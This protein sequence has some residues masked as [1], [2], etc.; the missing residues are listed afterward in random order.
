MKCFLAASSAEG[1]ISHFPDCYDPDGGWSAY[2]IK[3]GPGTGKSSFMKRV[4]KT[5]SERAKPS[6]EVHCASDP[7]SLDGVIL[8][9]ERIAIMDGT[10]PHVVEPRFV[11]AVETLL[12]FGRFWDANAL[13]RGREEI[14][15]LTLRNKELHKKAGAHISSAGAALKE[16]LA[17][18]QADPRRAETLS[19]EL[20]EKHLPIEGKGGR[21][22][23]AF[24]GGVTPTGL[25]YITEGE[26]AEKSIILD[27]SLDFASEV[28]R[29]FKA[30]ALNR[31]FETV[32][33][34]N[35]ILPSRLTDGVFIPALSLY[36]SADP[37]RHLGD[38]VLKELSSAADFIRQAKENH[39]LL[40]ECYIGAMDF[41][42]LDAF[43]E[44]FCE[45]LFD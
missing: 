22:W 45:T 32:T 10:A 21:E 17:R 25:L 19:V 13:K 29:R 31:G 35:P 34:K 42:A 15:G 16:R 5:A 1:F 20:I 38:D 8:P 41:K 2:I 24:S 26:L 14:I 4:L 9:T 39:D 23:F 6:V 3:G 40:E 27:G 37:Q 12:D 43:C 44:E 33:F 28:I 30:E 11:G 18:S 7:S 36:I